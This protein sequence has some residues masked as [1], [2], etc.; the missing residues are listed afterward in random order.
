MNHSWAPTHLLTC[1]SPVWVLATPRTMAR[2]APLSMGFSKARTREW[3]AMPSSRG[4]SQPMGQAHF[5]RLLW[6]LLSCNYWSGAPG[7]PF[8]NERSPRPRNG[9]SSC[10]TRKTQSNQKGIIK[11][12]VRRNETSFPSFSLFLKEVYKERSLASLVCKIG[13][14][15][16]GESKMS[17]Q[18]LERHPFRRIQWR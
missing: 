15:G 2:Q 6:S 1:L 8:C 18:F 5:S 11:K 12:T 9:E 7:A 13:K 4:S 10:V 17:S 16:L 14:L 3:G